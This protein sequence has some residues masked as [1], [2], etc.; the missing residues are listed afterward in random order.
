MVVREHILETTAVLLLD[1]FGPHLPVSLVAR[2]HHS[3]SREGALQYVGLNECWIGPTDHMFQS[4]VN[5]VDHGGS[6]LVDDRLN[7]SILIV[8]NIHMS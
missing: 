8:C 2:S 6:E 3:I 4:T 7:M 1:L 5:G